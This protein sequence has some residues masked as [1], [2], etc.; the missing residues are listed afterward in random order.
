MSKELLPYGAPEKKYLHTVLDKSTG[1]LATYDIRTGELVSFG[2]SLVNRESEYLYSPELGEYICS[3]HMGG[4]KLSEIVKMEGMPS[5]GVLNRWRS[6]VKAFDG[7]IK[8]AR[9]YR[10]TMLLEKAEDAIEDA[11]DRDST[12]IAKFKFDA[13]SKLAE[14]LSP[15]EYGAQTKVVGDKNQPLQLI[16]NTG[17][18]RGRDDTRPDVVVTEV[19]GESTDTDGEQ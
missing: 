5:M 4:M 13:L 14:K 16:V 11:V 17:I 1:K 2:G 15:N 19:I 8:L 6:A 7:G 3:L 18:I 10:A 12:L 9:Q